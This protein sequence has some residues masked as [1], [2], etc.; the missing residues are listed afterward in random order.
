MVIFFIHDLYQ[1]E[2]KENQERKIENKI[3]FLTRNNFSANISVNTVAKT[4]KIYT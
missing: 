1:S 2:D 3:S 4:G